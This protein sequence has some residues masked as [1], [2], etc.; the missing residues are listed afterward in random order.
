MARKNIY[1]GEDKL[2]Y[3][4]SVAILMRAFKESEMK[5]IWESYKEARIKSRAMTEPSEAQFKIAKTFKEHGGDLRSSAKA[6]RITPA[7]VSYAVKRV[8]VWEFVKE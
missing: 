3:Q 6:L 4:I 5:S 8:A 2:P 7:E 1:L